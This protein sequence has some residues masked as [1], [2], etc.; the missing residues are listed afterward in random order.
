[1]GEN[2]MM[3]AEAA[4]ARLHQIDRAWSEQEMDTATRRVLV[5]EVSERF[6]DYL[7][8]KYAEGLNEDTRKVIFAEALDRGHANGMYDVESE[9]GDL[10]MFARSILQA[11]SR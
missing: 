6:A 8:Q 1:M 3:T 2:E 5:G 7:G 4:D 11:V 10:V 9:Y